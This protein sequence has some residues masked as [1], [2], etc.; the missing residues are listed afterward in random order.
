MIEY[1]VI[2]WIKIRMYDGVGMRA[3]RQSPAG[4]PA[5]AFISG[6]LLGKLPSLNF[7]FQISGIKIF[8]LRRLRYSMQRL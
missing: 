8:L 7:C 2:S 1:S 3:G 6:V 4:I 5:P